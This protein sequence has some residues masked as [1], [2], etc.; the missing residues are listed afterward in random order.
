MH[1]TSIIYT[2]TTYLDGNVVVLKRIIMFVEILHMTHLDGKK[3]QI[4]EI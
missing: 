2:K 4:H 3:F 1:K